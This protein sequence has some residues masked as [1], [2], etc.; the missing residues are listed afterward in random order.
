MVIV[1]KAYTVGIL[2]DLSQENL[3]WLFLRSPFPSGHH[4]TLSFL[5]KNTTV[6][7]SEK[8]CLFRF[9]PQMQSSEGDADRPGFRLGTHGGGRGW[10][11]T[12]WQPKGWAGNTGP[13]PH[14]DGQEVPVSSRLQPCQWNWSLGQVTECAPTSKALLHMPP[15]QPR[16]RAAGHWDTPLIIAHQDQSLRSAPCCGSLPNQMPEFCWNCPRPQRTCA[17][18]MQMW[19][20]RANSVLLFPPITSCCVPTGF[21]QD[22]SLSLS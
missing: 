14:P 1:R 10:W 16:S 18:A 9:H 22:L 17:E 15:H 8:W 13:D 3:S 7:P 12:S 2:C 11:R 4:T 19:M 6:A 21:N 20:R 5:N